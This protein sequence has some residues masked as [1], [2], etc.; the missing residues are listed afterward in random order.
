MANREFKRRQQRDERR[1]AESE[2]PFTGHED[3]GVK[4]KRTPPAEYLSEVRGEMRKVAWPNRS[5]V[6]N[7]T[8]VVLVATAF[9][10]GLTFGFDFV[11]GR[12]IFT[13]FG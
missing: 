5:E 3:V 12:L 7:Y 9:L 10:M 2:Q 11:F 13:I 4:R 1:A 8:I 6:I